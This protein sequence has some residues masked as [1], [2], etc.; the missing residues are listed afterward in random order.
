MYIEEVVLLS[1][2]F[3]SSDIKV[4]EIFDNLLPESNPHIAK[5]KPEELHF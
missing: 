5:P 4:L 3:M 1:Q 2:E